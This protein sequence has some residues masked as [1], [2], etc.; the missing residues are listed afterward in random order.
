MDKGKIWIAGAV[1]AIIVLI[2]G[3]WLLGIAPQL[4][5]AASANTDRVNAVVTNANNQRLLAKLKSDYQNIDALKNQLL[6]LRQAVPPK[7]DIPSFVTELNTLSGANKVTL[8][9][10]TVSDAK[11]YTP[12]S[13]TPASGTS[14][15]NPPQPNAKV[16]ASN[17]V[18]VPVQI[19][20]TGDY[21][22]VLSFVNDVQMGQ[23]LVLV[24][25]L[26]TTGATDAKGAKGNSTTTGGSQKVDSTLGGFIYVLC[27]TT[28]SN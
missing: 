16:S 4:A 19:S 5:I 11:P 7:E 26:T 14:K 17:F 13:Q 6:A 2:G 20:V 18:V 22:R 1:L 3:G 25:S 21:G 10:L 27:S 9:S 12:A 8:K 24:S 28:C 15:T 23:R